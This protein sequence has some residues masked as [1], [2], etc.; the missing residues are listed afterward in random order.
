MRDKSEQI[1]NI[2]L[3]I[4]R[5]REKIE[6]LDKNLIELSSDT[7]KYRQNIDEHN[8]V[9][10]D[11]KK[12]KDQLQSERNEHWRKENNLQ[13]NVSSLKE[14]LS[15]ADQTLRSMAGKPILNGRDSVQKVLDTFKERGGAV[16]SS[17]Y[18]SMYGMLFNLY[19][20]NIKTVLKM[21]LLP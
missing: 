16:S 10:Y 14:E 15:K 17:I 6:Q 5:D 7:E 9:F 12:K 3:E 18:N 21:F 1:K 4:E 19:R 2:A 13:A 20:R 11:M 8:K